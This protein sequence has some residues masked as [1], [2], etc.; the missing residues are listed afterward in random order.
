MTEKIQQLIEDIKL[1]YKMLYSQ[2]VEERNLRLKQN[3][4]LSSL[5]DEVSVLKS[6][7]SDFEIENLK[8]KVDLDTIIQERIEERNSSLKIRNQ[9]IDDLVRE[10]EHCITQLK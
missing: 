9:E 8:L 1:K 5:N 4:E 10:I 7:I 3:A 2:L 6:K